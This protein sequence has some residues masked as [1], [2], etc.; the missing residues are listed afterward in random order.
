MA[1][2]NDKLAQLSMR[3][4]IK[5]VATDL[6]IM[7]GCP[8]L[9]FQQIAEILDC[10]R[11]NIHYHYRHK[12]LLVEEVTV[13]YC[14]RTIGHFDQI[15]GSD[16]SLK[17]K[18]RQSMQFNQTRYLK[19]NPQ[20]NTNNPWSLIARMRLER[21]IITPVARE[22]VARYS[23]ELQRCVIGGMRRSIERGELRPDTPVELVSLPLIE[24]AN[25][26]DPITRDA[27]QFD[28]LRQMYEA[29]DCL[30]HE[31]YGVRT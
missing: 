16:F 28:R 9:R 23:M 3:E 24:L 2:A 27:G 25:S 22:A 13:E 20:G 12:H 6:L 30:I 29:F 5:E 15:W 7:H 17:E 19:R 14:Q 8:G 10:T 18:I 4:K 31:A 11:G 26:A 21:D 1:N